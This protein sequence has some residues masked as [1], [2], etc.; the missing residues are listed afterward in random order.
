MQ[1]DDK[2]VIEV[3]RANTENVVC[4]H[5]SCACMSRY[6]IHQIAFLE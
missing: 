2:V 4:I 6:H 1:E 3:N 5:S